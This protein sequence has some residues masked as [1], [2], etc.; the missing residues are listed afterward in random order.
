MK[1]LAALLLTFSIILICTS[2][3]NSSKENTLAEIEPQLSQVQSICELAV[4]DCYYHNVA[5]FLE[6]DASGFLWWKRI[7]IFG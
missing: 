6:E 4:M 5:K 1:R 2:C 7:S 3:G